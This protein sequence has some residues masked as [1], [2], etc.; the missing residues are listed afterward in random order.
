MKITKRQLKRIVETALKEDNRF[1]DDPMD[2]PVPVD[3]PPISQSGTNDEEF[4]EAV[5]RYTD[6][7]AMFKEDEYNP[8][9]TRGTKENWSHQVVLAQRHLLEELS[10]SI[11]QAVSYID[12][13][14][15]DGQYWDGEIS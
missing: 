6:K 12:D 1:L 11:A 2:H 4:T 3:L 8:E 13:R 5:E 14:L 7:W 15:D 9:Y 10:S